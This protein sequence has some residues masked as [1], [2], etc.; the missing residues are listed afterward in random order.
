MKRKGLACSPWNF[1]TRQKAAT[2]KQRGNTL[3]VEVLSQAELLSLSVPFHW[4]DSA[5]SATFG[6]CRTESTLVMC[7]M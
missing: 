4:G 6:D 3:K 7:L 2:S 1:G 5:S